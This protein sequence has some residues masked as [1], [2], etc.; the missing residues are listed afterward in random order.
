MTLVISPVPREGS[1]LKA[2]FW[3]EGQWAELLW[4]RQLFW[5]GFHKKGMFPWPRKHI[6]LKSHL[7]Q[8]TVLTRS[9]HVPCLSPSSLRAMVPIQGHTKDLTTKPCRG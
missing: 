9:F 8:T 4:A 7:K 5:E 3:W 6:V 2:P 1:A